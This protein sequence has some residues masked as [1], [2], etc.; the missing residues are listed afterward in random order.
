MEPGSVNLYAELLKTAGMLGIVLGILISL[1]FLFKRFVSTGTMGGDK[2][3]IRLLSSFYLGNREKLI[4]VEVENKRLFL[5][6]TQHNISLLK[7]LEKSEESESLGE[8]EN[9][10]F[11]NILKNSLIKGKFFSRKGKKAEDDE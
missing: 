2:S 8:D 6:V 1:L 11:A 10:D 4:L 9:R 5:G 7:E 3:K